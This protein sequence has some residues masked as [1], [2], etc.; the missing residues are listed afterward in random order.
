MVERP[1][2]AIGTVIRESTVRELARAAGFTRVEV[3]NVDDGYFRFYE[4]H[5]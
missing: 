5:R 3:L 1:S 2:A 4:L